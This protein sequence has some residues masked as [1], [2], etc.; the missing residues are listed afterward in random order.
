[1]YV[2]AVLEEDR[3]WSIVKANPAD[4]TAWTALIQE[5]D[6]LV[7]HLC[8]CLWFCCCMYKNMQLSK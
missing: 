1:M 6:K 5:V 2:A 4:F 3:L 7:L 8:L